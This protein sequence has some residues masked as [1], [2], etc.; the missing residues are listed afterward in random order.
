MFE[1]IDLITLQETMQISEVLFYT[2]ILE[3]GNF[4]NI[5]IHSKI[6]TEQLFVSEDFALKELINECPLSNDTI[7]VFIEDFGTRNF[8][9]IYFQLVA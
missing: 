5:H 1:T 2:Q 4:S 3:L 6:F 8:C 7:L 9:V